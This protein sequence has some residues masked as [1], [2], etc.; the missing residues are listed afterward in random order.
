MRLWP[1]ARAG[2][3]GFVR[4]LRLQ[5]IAGTGTVAS[6]LTV[7]PVNSI[8]LMR[9]FI[10]FPLDCT[11]CLSNFSGRAIDVYKERRVQCRSGEWVERHIRRGYLDHAFLC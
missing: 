6:E 11:Q 5:T 1:K 8:Q 4:R 9:S 10:H 2:G 3:C 7:N